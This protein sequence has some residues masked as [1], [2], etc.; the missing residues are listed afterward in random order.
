MEAVHQG[1][2]QQVAALQGRVQAV[3]KGFAALPV[4]AELAAAAP[5]PVTLP[6]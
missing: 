4:D 2:V 1:N 5:A 6:G 3:A